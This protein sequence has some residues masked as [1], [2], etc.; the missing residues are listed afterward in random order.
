MAQ[1]I[2]TQSHDYRGETLTNI[3]EIVFQGTNLFAT[4]GAD[5]FGGTGIS[6][7][8]TLTHDF[9]SPRDDAGDPAGAGGVLGRRLD[10]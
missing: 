8:V 4:F 10:V 2:V 6:N 5:Q 3:T 1:L 7:N 9:T